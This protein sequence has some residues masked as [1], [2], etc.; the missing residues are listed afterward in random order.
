M[1]RLL[2]LLP[3]I[4]YF[5]G[6]TSGTNVYY[7]VPRE[8]IEPDLM[9]K[10]IDDSKADL[11]GLVVF[12]D[13][14]HGG[15]NRE[16]QGPQGLANEADVNLKVGL[17]L[18]DFLTQAGARV[19]M[20]RDIDKTVSLKERSELANASGAD[21]FISIHHNAPGKAGDNWT[22][23]TSTYYHATENDYEYEPM[24]RD[25][26][27]YIQRDLAYAMRNAGGAGSFDGT[28]S[29]YWIYPGAGFSVLRH[30]KIPSVLLECGFHTHNW[31]EVRL[32]IEEFNKVEAWGIFRGLSRYYKNGVPKI[33]FLKQDFESN[34]NNL[35]FKVTDKNGIDKNSIKVFVDSIRTNTFEFIESESIVKVS[36]SS[37]NEKEVIRV[38]AMN[39][40]GN[41]S[42]PFH[43]E[44]VLRKN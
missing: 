28:Y 37:N 31:E 14:G 44:A 4:F 12:L 1:K 22:N 21:I 36:V 18:R 30:T 33:S 32:S 15:D 38:M 9:T 6:C 25:L 39:K 27:K 2:F 26:A 19:I 5:I 17:F 40:K 29:D 23:Y 20:S 34:A 11:T 24:E 13:P 16:N 42:Y 41:T 10:A 35:Y 7:D 8:F 3:I 43:Y